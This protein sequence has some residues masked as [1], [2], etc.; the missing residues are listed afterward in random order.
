MSE[1]DSVRLSVCM[2]VCNGAEFLEEQLN[3]I[4]IQLGTNDE[5]I[6]CDDKSDDF[7]VG[8]ISSVGDPRIH[9]YLNDKRLGHVKNFELAISLARGNVIFLADQDDIWTSNRLALFI[10]KLA[11][12]K[13]PGLVVGNFLEVDNTASHLDTKMNRLQLAGSKGSRL[14]I[15]LSILIG[16]SKY[17]GCCF[18]FHRSLTKLILPFPSKI[19]AHDMW[20][21]LV[22]SL[23]AS[24]AVIDEVTLLRRIHGKNLTSPK[25]RG[26]NAICSSRL[27][28]VSE[29][30]LLLTRRWVGKLR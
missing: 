1:R 15:A 14:P 25:R 19:E 30:L 2:A 17:Y 10:E 21:G 8:I 5:I 23:C 7:S 24:V 16:R 6:I 18:A 22:A 26:L 12:I 9:L 28:Y 11:Q 4:L 27:K 20:I 13:S 3:S 29:L